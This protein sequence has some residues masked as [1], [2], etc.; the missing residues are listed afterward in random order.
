[1]TGDRNA[2]ADRE[3]NRREPTDSE[4]GNSPPGD[5]ELCNYGTT[6]KRISASLLDAEVVPLDS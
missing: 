6:T 5:R 4:H 2:D 3:S 1:M